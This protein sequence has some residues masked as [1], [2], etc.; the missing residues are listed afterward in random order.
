VAAASCTETLSTGELQNEQLLHEMLCELVMG[1]DEAVATDVGWSRNRFLFYF[2]KYEI[3]TEVILIS[4]NFVVLS[5]AK[6][7]EIV[8]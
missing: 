4:R 2:A 8:S 5:F 3:T 1:H 6:F 7:R